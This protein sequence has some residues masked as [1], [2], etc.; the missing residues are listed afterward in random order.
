M[1]SSGVNQ[2]VISTYL[3]LSVE[4]TTLEKTLSKNSDPQKSVVFKVWRKTGFFFMNSPPPF[5]QPPSSTPLFN[6]FSLGNN[7]SLGSGGRGEKNQ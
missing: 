3:A 7:H 2:P 4:Q 6:F 1:T 5:L